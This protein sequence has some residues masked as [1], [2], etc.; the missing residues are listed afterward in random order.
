MH[1]IQNTHKHHLISLLANP[2]H[3][4]HY[5]TTVLPQITAQTLIS[6]Q[7]FFT[8]ATKQDQCI[9]VEDSRAV[10]NL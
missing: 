6:F 8:Q 7:R 5:L 2:M 4:I 9:L 10:Y 3:S 1:G